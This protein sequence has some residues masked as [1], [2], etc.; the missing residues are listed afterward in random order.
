M[1]KT[2]P[3][4]KVSILGAAAV[5]AGAAAGAYYFYG[6]KEAKKHRQHMASWM[7]KAEKEIVT[8]VKK[9]KNT[10]LSEKNVKAI[11]ATVSKK[12]EQVQKL[13]KK[14]VAEFARVVG[15]AWKDVAAE[16]KK[17]AGA[18]KKTVKKVVAKGTKVAKKTVKK[19][20]KKIS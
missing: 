6:S 16:L 7:Q 4:S 2:K 12:Y 8:E 14:D 17:E 9:L 10:A 3:I 1:K 18:A 11:I 20:V 19:A 5:A 13:D 15:G